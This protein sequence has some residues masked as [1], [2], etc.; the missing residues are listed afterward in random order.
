[1]ENVPYNPENDVCLN[2][3]R[4]AVVPCDSPQAHFKLRPPFDELSDEEA[5]ALGLSKKPAAPAE[6][7]VVEMGEADEP[8]EKTVSAAPANKAVA[9]SSNK[10]NA[11]KK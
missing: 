3:D 1:M 5:E 6:P 4:S 2:A 10:G 9:A 7:E 11:G 8:E